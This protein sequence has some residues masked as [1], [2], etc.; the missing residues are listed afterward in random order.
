MG[1]TER[2]CS[3]ITSSVKLHSTPV[4]AKK[5]HIID[6]FFAA[7]FQGIPVLHLNSFLSFYSSSETVLSSVS[8]LFP[9]PAPR[10]FIVTSQRNQPTAPSARLVCQ[11]R[12]LHL[13]LYNQCCVCAELTDKLILNEPAAT[14][15]VFNAMY[16]S[17][18]PGH[19][20]SVVVFLF[21]ASDPK[22]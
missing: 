22:W 1:R 19:K 13:V 11:R 15:A 18:L 10:V 21:F 20:T 17:S 8:A 2:W 3:S 9:S 4:S 7:A 12:S 16:P 14:L 5:R 6:C